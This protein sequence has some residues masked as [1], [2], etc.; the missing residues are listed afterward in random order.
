MCISLFCYEITLLKCV[1]PYILLNARPNWTWFH[2]ITS[3]PKVTKGSSSILLLD[4][5]SLLAAPSLSGGD[6]K[7][8]VPMFTHAG[9]ARKTT[10]TPECLTAVYPS[11]E[12]AGSN[13]VRLDYW[14]FP[15]LHT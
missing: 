9:N 6:E 11:I 14:A 4:T 5:V 15:N 10:E 1:S 12:T 2:F 3:S 13:S 7:K 8:L